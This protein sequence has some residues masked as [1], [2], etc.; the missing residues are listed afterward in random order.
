MDEGADEILASIARLAQR[1]VDARAAHSMSRTMVTAHSM[2]PSCATL[3]SSAFE[4]LLHRG[5]VMPVPDTAD[6][7][8][9]PNAAAPLEP[10]VAAGP[11]PVWTFPE[12]GA[13]RGGLDPISRSSASIRDERQ[14]LRPLRHLRK[15]ATPCSSRAPTR[16]LPQAAVHHVRRHASRPGRVSRGVTTLNEKQIA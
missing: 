3:A 9:R 8:P 15:R 10:T 5:Q 11:E 16:G 14:A 2:R 12:P 6:T 7:S 1:T 4:P 13:V